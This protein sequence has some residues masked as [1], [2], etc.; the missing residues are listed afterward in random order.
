[1]AVNYGGTVN[2][3]QAVLP[4]MARRR[5]G[6]LILFGSTGGSV[7]VPDCGAYCASKAAT[8]VYAEML[9]EEMRGSGCHVQSKDHLRLDRKEPIRRP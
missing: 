3:V 6:E 9:I 5:A 8:N 2:A 1:M 7:L 4:A